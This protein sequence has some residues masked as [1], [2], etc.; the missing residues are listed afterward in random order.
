MI[1]PTVGGVN[2][3]SYDFG[4]VRARPQ[5]LRPM[6]RPKGQSETTNADRAVES[7]ESTPLVGTR[8]PPLKADF[9]KDHKT[10]NTYTNK[11]WASLND[12]DRANYIRSVAKRLNELH[13]LDYSPRVVTCT[14]F[15]ESCFR[16]QEMDKVEVNTGAGLCQVSR[17]TFVDLFNNASWFRSKVAG[18]Q[19][20]TDGAVLHKAMAGS[21]E[22]QI[23]GCISIMHQK[24]IYLGGKPSSDRMPA[25]LQAYKGNSVNTGNA[26]QNAAGRK[27]NEDYANKIFT[28][29]ECIRNEDKSAKKKADEITMACLEEARNSCGDW[30]V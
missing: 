26:A 21:M 8:F 27:I 14:T 7:V 25:V 28:C 9:S 1:A 23:E 18:F 15:R 10:A 12:L 20:I 2:F 13:G 4:P 22:A 11:E 24:N 3:E 29:A 19:D 5:E 16:P 17:P 30:G 6:A